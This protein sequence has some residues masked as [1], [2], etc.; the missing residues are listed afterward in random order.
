MIKLEY[1]IILLLSTF[2]L[3]LFIKNEYKIGKFLSVLDIPK[4]GKIHK[5][6]T[7]LIGSFPILVIS[8]IILIYFSF[9]G[10]N[11]D[12]FYIL[13]YSYLFFIIGYFDDRY[14]LNAYLKLTISVIIT[15]IAVSSF[16]FFIIEKIYLKSLNKII[17]LDKIKYFFTML[18][19]LLF[20]NALNLMDGINGL[21]AGFSSLILI[22]LSLISNNEVIFGLLFMI[23]ILMFINTFQIIKGRYFLGDSG[24][25]FLGCLIGLST[26]TIYNQ[27]LIAGKFIPVE[28]IFIFFMIPGVDMFR[29]FLIRILKKK[30]PFSRDLNHLHH[31]M[32]KLFTL[33]QTLTIYLFIF[34]LT[35]F[36]SY[37]EI[38]NT[39]L[40]IFL[41]LVIYI[42]FISFS[43]KKFNETSR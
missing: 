21:V 15:L 19:I 2:I 7:P 41:Y 22:L 38:I 26:I 28:K 30:D 8:L 37:Y 11:Q 24:T 13:I 36:L 6:I 3:I 39:L 35:N 4:E 40:I 10:K 16:E 12:I 18:C 29:L 9:I 14:G 17:F 32:L 34:L 5:K 23:S 1:L 43:K 42:F 33:Y 25:L 27:Q 31:L 20:V